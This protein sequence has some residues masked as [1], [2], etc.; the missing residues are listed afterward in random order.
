MP[1]QHFPR[2]IPIT[3]ALGPPIFVFLTLVTQAQPLFEGNVG[4]GYF[5]Q[6]LRDG[7]DRRIGSILKS[8]WRWKK[9]MIGVLS[10]RVFG[11]G[12]L[13]VNKRKTA[14]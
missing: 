12:F 13:Q 2:T 10:L 7:D 11:Y 14:N 4:E 5:P 1:A 8:A 3:I 9:K 6:R